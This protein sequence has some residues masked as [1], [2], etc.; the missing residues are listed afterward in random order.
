MSP[1]P[2]RLARAARAPALASIALLLAARLPPAAAARAAG[3][4]PH[5]VFIV[6]DDLG[7]NDISLHSSPAQIPTP[8]IDALASGGVELQNYHVQSVCSPSRSSFL[9]GRHVIHTGIYFPFGQG[10]VDHL[11]TDV[12]LLP[13]YLQRCCN[14]STHAV[15]KY[16]L[17]QGALN[18]LPTGRGFD[19][20]LGYYSG[21]E[22]HVTHDTT[23][24]YDFNVGDAARPFASV[25][26]A[27]QYNNSWST[28]VFT[29]TAVDLIRGFDAQHSSL[30]L[31]LAYQDVHWPLQAPDEWFQRFAGKTGTGAG[32][33]ER[34]YVCAMAAFMDEGV[35]NVTRALK[36]AGMF[37]D[38]FIIFSADNGGPTNLNEGTESN[39]FPM[40]GGKNTLWEGG[41]RVNG[42]V[43]GPGLQ[44]V[45]AVSSMKMHATDWLPTL[46]RM[47]SGRNWTE[48][49]SADEPPY[50]LGDGLD[51]W[52]AL[53][54]GDAS[55]SPRDWLVLETHPRNASDRIHGDAFIKGDWK[56]LRYQYSPDEENAWHPP[57]GQDPSKVA[58]QL[59]CPPPPANISASQCSQSAGWCLFNVSADPCEQNDLAAQHPDIVAQL[60]AQLGPFMDTAV[61]MI[62]AVGP[63]PLVLP[64]DD[65]TLTWAPSD[66]P[67]VSD[68][69]CSR[70]G[71]CVAATGLCACS[72]GWTGEHCGALDVQPV[73]PGEGFN[74]L[75]EATSSWGGSAVFAEEDGLWHLFFSRMLEHCTLAQWQTNS[76]CWHATS[77]SPTG[78]F[79]NESQ[80]VGPFSHNCLVRRAADKTF[81]LFHIGDGGESSSVV[82]CSSGAAPGAA[83]RGGASD[84][85]GGDIGYNTL[86]YSSS[87]WGPWTPLGYSILNGSGVAGDWDEIITNL[88]PWPLAD[89]SLL[90]GFR[91]KNT[92]NKVER[93]GMA[94]APS[95]RGPYTK[96]VD[97]P[98]LA[99]KLAQDSDVTGEDPVVWTTPDG[100]GHMLWHVCCDSSNGT[101]NGNSSTVGRH[102]FTP[103][104]G[105]WRKWSISLEPAYTTSVTWV[106]GSAGTVARRERPQLV[107]DA[108]SGAPL[109]LFNGVTV[110]GGSSASF[111]MAARIGA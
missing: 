52:D 42:I 18:Q 32:S 94:T 51:V 50:L 98:I 23:G 17:G 9:S 7:Y 85:A 83:P 34:Q 26:P 102:A 37:D 61:P 100:I 55:R 107:L 103:V 25:Q 104:A 21:A 57:P 15:G 111:T 78:P 70:N 46:V 44:K 48:F 38:T 62:P 41:T 49:I 65:G 79:A 58:Y 89:G 77:S 43:H 3:L 35:G 87:V 81:L 91:G 76:A 16:H 4:P 101:Y 8:N 86:R 22:D 14:Y 73:D 75:G 5:I 40:R 99:P 72:A 69:H 84:E 56:I 13:Q 108:A 93:L 33:Q 45:D 92:T 19:T 30:F 90:V 66:G 105:D 20:Y 97:K 68:S 47:A 39:N 80:V 31:Y 53:S 106:N 59:G 12:T 88:A 54:S 10:T 82:N 109:V 110:V 1:P 28:D 6:A 27:T 29:S 71:V 64:L 60:V 11:R 24:A 2:R 67:C 74:R 96:L 95:W 36:D 63:L